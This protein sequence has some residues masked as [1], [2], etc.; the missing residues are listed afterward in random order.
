MANNIRDKSFPAAYWKTLSA[1]RKNIT[2]EKVFQVYTRINPTVYWHGM[3]KQQAIKSGHVMEAPH[4]GGRGGAHMKA[5]NASGRIKDTSSRRTLHRP[6]VAPG[7]SSGGFDV[8]E[9]TR[10][11]E[12]PRKSPSRSSSTSPSKYLQQRGD[13]KESY[14][15][16]SVDAND[17]SQAPDELDPAKH[18]EASSTGEDPPSLPSPST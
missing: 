9:E 7:L 4:A 17:L 11:D 6:K 1:R 10:E 18:K 3:S 15:V 13:V 12:S 16:V 8:L 2:D 5:N 14:R